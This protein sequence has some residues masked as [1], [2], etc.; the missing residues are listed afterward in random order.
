MR[1]NARDENKNAKLL[2]NI[3]LEKLMNLAEQ[4]GGKDESSS[5]VIQP[6]MEIIDQSVKWKSLVEW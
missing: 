1:H 6:K 5:V 3:E 2:C 4:T